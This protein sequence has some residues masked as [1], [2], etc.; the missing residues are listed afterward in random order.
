[1]AEKRYLI[2]SADDYGIDAQTNAAIAELFEGGYITSASIIAVGDRAKQAA[3]KSAECGY[4]VGVH[5][6]FTSDWEDKRWQSL[7]GAESLCDEH[8]LFCQKAQ[9][10]DNAKSFEVTKEMNAQ[11]RFL[12]NHGCKVDHADSHN[13]TLYI[14]S[15]RFF[16]SNAFRFCAHHKLPFR[17]PTST[18]YQDRHFPRGVPK[19][20]RLAYYGMALWGR[21]I[22]VKMLDDLITH[23]YPMSDIPSYNTLLDY[24]VN[25]LRT[26]VP[27]I[28]EL[29]LH[30][31]Y[32]LLDSKNAGNEWTKREYEL[33][34]L[35][36]GDLLQVARE[37]GIELV[38]WKD[39]PFKS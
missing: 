12:H 21:I 37:E 7:S 30:P 28:T 27:G 25:Q 19:N 3:A 15:G 8:G 4:S 39:A 11:L 14:T 13:G 1:M 24:Y 16:F 9:F 18:H 29:Y 33:R 5:F 22:G 20:E 26:S 35:R 38:S 2:I 34:L 32:P 6:A 23:P 36:S 10:V 17:Y 31:S